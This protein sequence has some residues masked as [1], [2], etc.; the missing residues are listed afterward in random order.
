MLNEVRCQLATAEAYLKGSKGFCMDYQ[1]TYD[2]ADNLCAMKYPKAFWLRARIHS[3]EKTEFFNE[4]WM[5]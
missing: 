1:Q 2:I 5:I 3:L 4:E